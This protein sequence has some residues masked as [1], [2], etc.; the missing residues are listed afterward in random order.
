MIGPA[1]AD[2]LFAFSLMKN[3][4]CGNFAYVILIIFVGFGLRISSRLPRNMWKHSSD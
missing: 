3:I 1:A 2:W 4:L